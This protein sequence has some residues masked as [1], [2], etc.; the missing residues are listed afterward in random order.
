MLAWAGERGQ[1][2]CENNYLKETCIPQRI[3]TVLLISERLDARSLFIHSPIH[4]QNTDWAM[5]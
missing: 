2:R 3:N 5:C 4:S 1:Q